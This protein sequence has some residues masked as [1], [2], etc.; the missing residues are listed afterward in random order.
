MNLELGGEEA[1]LCVLLTVHKT[2]VR[3][4][5]ACSFALVLNLRMSSR[6]Y[7]HELLKNRVSQS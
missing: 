7:C 1:L 4:F 6:N 5:V 3:E 2:A